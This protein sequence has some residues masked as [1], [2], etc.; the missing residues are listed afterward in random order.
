MLSL[1]RAR[2]LEVL[3][4]VGPLVLAVCVLQV[5]VI[6]APFAA[7][8]QFLV[9]AALAAVGMLLLFTGIELGV[10]PMGR[11]V[12]AELPRRG[13][14]WVIIVIAF[15]IGFATTLPEPDVLVLSEQI[16]EASSGRVSER[17]ILYSIGLGVAAF[18]AIAM[19]RIVLGWP[20]RH[21]LAV[22]YLSVV[23]LAV[24]APPE[25]VSLAFDGGSVTTGV[26]SAPVI[27]AMAIGLS[28]VLAGRSAV[29]DGFGI[30]GFASIG[31]IIIILF[32]GLL[33]A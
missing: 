20:M 30:V 17:S 9:G 19:A 10:L 8:A 27:I 7:F 6:H 23:V 1:L 28:S 2:A 33:R 29:S 4:A 5:A 18:T 26:L 21:L 31:P 11:F 22:A 32:M 24:F 15:V 3:K 14:L 25:F 16:D 13:S 12:G